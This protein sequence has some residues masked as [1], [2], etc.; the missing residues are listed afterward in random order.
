M[1]MLGVSALVPVWVARGVLGFIVASL[2]RHRRQQ[3]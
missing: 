2:N 1:T 3:P